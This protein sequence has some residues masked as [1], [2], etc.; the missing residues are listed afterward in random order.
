MDFL[1]K[2]VWKIH[3]PVKALDCGYGFPDMLLMF[4]MPKGST[5]TGIDTAQRFWEGDCAIICYKILFLQF[6]LYK[7]S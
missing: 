7:G 4:L 1:T 2:R 3:K 5:Y 6:C